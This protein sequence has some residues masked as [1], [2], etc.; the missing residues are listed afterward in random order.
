MDRLVRILAAPV[1]LAQALRLRRTALILPEPKGARTG[2]IGAGPPLRLLI[3]GDSSGAGVGVDHQDDALLGHLTRALATDYCL[4][5]QLLA[6]TGATS[7]HA[8]KMLDQAGP[9]DVA[10]IALGVNDVTRLTSASKWLAVQ[11]TLFQRLRDQH[12]ARLICVTPIPP[13]GEF[14]LLPNPLRWVLGRH[15]ARLQTARH[16][17]FAQ[18]PE[19]C[20]LSFDLPMDPTLMA[21]DGFHPGAQ[22]YRIWGETTAQA[23]RAARPFILP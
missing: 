21:Q 12:G 14:P 20:P 2:R 3:L 1:L 18:Y 11:N 7:P 17:L 16:A 10:V 4:E 8:L 13:M 15:A 19:Y 9:I 6:R 22:A 5:W 23:I